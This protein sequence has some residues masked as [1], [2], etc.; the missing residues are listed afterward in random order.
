MTTS[1]DPATDVAPRPA[2]PPARRRT[3]LLFVTITFHPEPGAL[4]GLPLARRLVES[5]EFDVTVLTAVPWYPL[6]RT[7]P[8]YRQ[9]LWQWETIDGV[10][11]LRVPIYPSHDSSAARRIATYASFMLSALCVGLPLVGRADAVYHVDN[12]PTTGLVTLLYARLRGVPVVQHVGDLWPESVTESGMLPR[13]IAAR[14][15]GGLLGRL[16]DFVYRHDDR[17]TVLSPGF[18]RALLAR[19]VSP[20][21]IEVLPNWAEEDRFFPV[22]YDA[23]LAE[24]LGFAGKFNVVYAGNIGPLQS[25]ET[26][27]RAAAAVRDLTDL[28]IVIV[29]SGPRE[30]GVRALAASL[31]AHN[32]RFLGRRPID[33]MNGINALADVLLVHLADRPFL[34]ST[35]P[36]KVQ[37]AL[38]SAK[39]VLLGVRGDAADLIR[40]SA[41]GVTFAPGDA[42]DLAA[43][44]RELHA[45]P[46]AAL[47]AMGARGRAYYHDHLSLDIG[48]RRMAQLFADVAHAG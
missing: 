5:G 26:V 42:D 37:V 12:L 8:G 41:G 13:G 45:M 34:H 1:L 32:V 3:R 7:Y 11:V 16:C 31:D 44:L 23:A 21:R 36:S 40:A 43:R 35:I 33:A 47:A 17:L 19:G 38:V 2:R 10:R 48:H 46:R 14:V 18:E 27:V 39:P 22:A 15:V 30:G 25:L 9:R 20:S 28:Q 29:G 24:E 4:R 6:G